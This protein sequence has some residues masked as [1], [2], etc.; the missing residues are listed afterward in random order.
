M[1]EMWLNIRYVISWQ[2]ISIFLGWLQRIICASVYSVGLSLYIQSL[3]H[4][5]Q[6][7]GIEFRHLVV[8]AS[9]RSES[10]HG[11]RGSNMV[12]SEC[13]IIP[14][15][16]KIHASNSQTWLYQ[17]VSWGVATNPS[18]ASTQQFKESKPSIFHSGKNSMSHQLFW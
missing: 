11:H 16:G 6:C 1:C 15:E 14:K 4:G 10:Y 5:H 2:D 17:V 13:L 7:T 8:A 9:R 3:N 12:R 18:E